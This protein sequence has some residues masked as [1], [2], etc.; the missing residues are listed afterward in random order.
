ML[1]RLFV[2]TMLGIVVGCLVALLAVGF[3]DF[4]IW[5]NDQLAISPRSRMLFEYPGWLPIVT[6]AVPTCAGIMVGAIIHQI[7]EK[8]PH[9]IPDS[10][11][12]SQTLEGKMPLKAGILSTIASIVSLGS[13]ASVGQYGPLAHMGSVVGSWISHCFAKNQYL[14]T[15]GIGCGA[16]AAISTAFNAPIAGLIFAHEVILRHYSLRSFAPITVAATI[17]YVVANQVFARPP[18]FRI[19]HFQLHSPYEFVGF[20]IIGVMGAFVAM[21]LIRGVLLS[22]S[23][24]KKISLPGPVKTGIAGFAVGLVAL[25]LPEILG[26]GKELLRFSIIEGAFSGS[27]LTL[28]LLTKI[29]LTSVCLGFGFAGGIFSPALLIGV[30]FGA[31][32]AERTTGIYLV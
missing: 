6:L 26:V 27:E 13:G 8:R 24:S 25:Q 30:L 1:L 32:V 29:L 5:L 14:G 3:V 9:N 7:P 28:I 18:L 19:E 12:A 20:I 10:I 22:G 15:I 21:L 16:A 17:G 4:V 11:R 23:I 31:L 2:V